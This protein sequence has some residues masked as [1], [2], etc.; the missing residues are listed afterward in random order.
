MRWLRHDAEVTG[1]PARPRPGEGLDLSSP[2]LT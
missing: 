2:E 1:V